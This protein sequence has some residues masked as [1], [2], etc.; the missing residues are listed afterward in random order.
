MPKALLFMALR[1]YGIGFGNHDVYGFGGLW[2]P[3]GTLALTSAIERFALLLLTAYP[4]NVIR[5]AL[6]G[7]CSMRE[8]LWE[9]G[10]LVLG[11]F[12]EML[13]QAKFMLNRYRRI[14]RS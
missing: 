11:K 8:N 12:P 3:I 2:M 13:G 9:G 6:R 7:K 5:L 10:A 1:P 14:P 4:L